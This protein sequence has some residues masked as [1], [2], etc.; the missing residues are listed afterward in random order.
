MTAWKRDA[1][2]EEHVGARLEQLLDG[3]EV[4]LLH[5]RRVPRSKSNIDHIAIGPGGITVIDAKN[6]RGKVRRDRVGGLFVDRHDILMVDGRDRTSLVRKVERQIAV[7]R[8]VL[9]TIEESSI[10]LRGALC[11]ADVDGLPILRSLS[12]DG[13]LADGPKPVAK[14]ARRPGPLTRER[15][16]ALWQR[17]AIA[18]PSA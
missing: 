17:L 8:R 13:I 4:R 11:F 7:V 16:D 1:E 12:V 10:D 2:G 9:D 6:I 18:L 5:D 3:S 15:I 14:L